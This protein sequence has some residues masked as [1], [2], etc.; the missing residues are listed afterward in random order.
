MPFSATER[1]NNADKLPAQIVG[2]ANDV[3]GIKWWYSETIGLSLITDPAKIWNEFASIPGAQTPAVADANVLANPTLLEKITVHLTPD[4]TSNNRAWMAREV[5]GNNNTPIYGNWIQPALI[6][7]NGTFSPGYSIRLYNGDPAGAG[8][9]LPTTYLPGANGAPSW[10][11][12]YSMGVLVVSTDE[13]ASYGALDLWVV[14]Y[15]YIGPTGGTGG[16]GTVDGIVTAQVD[17]Q[18]LNSALY[19]GNRMALVVIDNNGD[20]VYVP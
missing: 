15:R 6:R 13:A 5:Y 18:N 20:V 9:E 4:I 2:T 1:L 12:N 11:W 7:N 3:P 14:G 8:V 10:Q 19:T 17:V 16:A